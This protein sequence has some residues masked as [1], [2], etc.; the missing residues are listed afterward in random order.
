MREKSPLY[1]GIS[2]AI[3]CRGLGSCGTCAVKIKGEVSPPTLMEK[4]R[5]SVPPHRPDS[6]L[7]LAC[8]CRVLGDLKI[9]KHPGLWGS[10]ITTTS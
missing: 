3:H 9:T 8:Q 1:N 10:Q 7:R 6:G 5:L 4:W 2:K